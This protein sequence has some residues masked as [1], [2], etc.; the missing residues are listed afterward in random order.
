[1]DKKSPA[2]L[3]RCAGIIC[4]LA[5]CSVAGGRSGWRVDRGAPRQR[6][7]GAPH[8]P[9]TPTPLLPPTS[10]H[11]THT[12][13]QPV[14][15]GRPLLRRVLQTALGGA[16]QPGGARAPCVWVRAGVRDALGLRGPVARL[17]AC[18]PSLTHTHT[19]PT[20]PTHHSN[21][22]HPPPQHFDKSWLA[23]ATVK[24]LMYE[25]EAT[26]QV[27]APP[28]PPHPPLSPGLR[29]SMRVHIR[30]AVAQRALAPALPPQHPP[31]PPLPPPALT[32]E[33]RRPARR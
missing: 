6:Q 33:Q 17:H 9:L 4:S 12:H 5:L 8:P 27:G 2:V 13:L 23:H 16:P 28:L 3:A 1:M 19:S 26:V 11:P 14:Q 30:A 10:P 22:T 15:A 7:E 29:A 21:P 31:S 24:S 18:C 25:V 20:P 32:A